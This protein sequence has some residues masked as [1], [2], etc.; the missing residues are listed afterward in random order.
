MGNELL[1]QEFREMTRPMT[2]QE[3][4]EQVTVIQQVL[5]AVMKDGE[6]YGVVPGCGKKKVLLKPGAEKILSTFR[7]G[8]ELEIV[9][10]SDGYDF[11]YRVVCRGFYIPT[12]NTIGYGVGEA[13]TGEKKYKWRAAICHEEYEDTQE[14]KRQIAYLK[15]FKSGKPEAVEQVRQSPADLANTVL[16]MAKKRALV[17][18]CLTATACSDIFVQDIDD[19]DTAEATGANEQDQ[20]RYQPPRQSTPPVAS[21]AAGSKAISEKQRKM[22]YA[23]GMEHGLS[24]DY[25]ASLV[26]KHAGV[27]R[28]DEIPPEKFEAV[29]NAFQTENPEGL[30]V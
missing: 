25:M 30:G 15:D 20:P 4:K 2:V 11:R 1:K 14:T 10:L 8:T 19:S 12:G 17:D 28:S 26:K 27:D 16:K 7:I 6:H 23:V 29:L 9:D 18:L 13:S 5:A 3:V 24:K 22:L 21:S